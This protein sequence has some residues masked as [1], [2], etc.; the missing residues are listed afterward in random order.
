[1]ISN[2]KDSPNVFGEI[3]FRLGCFGVIFVLLRGLT[4]LGID[5]FWVNIIL[6]LFLA[7]VTIEAVNFF[8]NVRLKKSQVG[9]IL[10]LWLMHLLWPVIILDSSK[11]P[12]GSISEWRLISAALVFIFFSWWCLNTYKARKAKN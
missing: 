1:M 6:V 12:D 3:L 5:L 2:S 9:S 4:E 10:T 8:K 7:L 11:L